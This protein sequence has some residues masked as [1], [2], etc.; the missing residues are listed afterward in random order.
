MLRGQP[1]A[2]HAESGELLCLLDLNEVMRE[3]IALSL[4]NLQRN[5]VVLRSGL[6]EDLRPVIGD[7][8]QLHPVILNMLRNASDTIGDVEDR[9][10]ATADPIQREGVERVR[11]RLALRLEVKP[12]S[13]WRD[14]Y[15]SA[16]GWA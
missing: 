16:M 5:R 9:P 4:S 7:R 13:T 14:E 2:R 12:W 15:G 1:R 10:R 8:V 6:A 11:L 3:L